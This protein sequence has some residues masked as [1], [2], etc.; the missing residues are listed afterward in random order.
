MHNRVEEIMAKL[1]QGKGGILSGIF[2]TTLKEFFSPVANFK[3][4]LK[5]L[6][7]EPLP[8]EILNPPSSAPPV[9]GT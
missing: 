7:G 6:K 8:D 2:R 4:I 3:I 9:K 5:A 1:I